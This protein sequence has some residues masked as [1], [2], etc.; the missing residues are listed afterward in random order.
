MR[1]CDALEMKDQCRDAAMEATADSARHGPRPS[2]G[3]N[4]EGQREQQG[5][6]ASGDPC[7]GKRRET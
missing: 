7:K 1:T 6:G 2:S 3:A 4:S 5:Q